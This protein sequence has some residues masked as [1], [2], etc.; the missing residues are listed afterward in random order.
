VDWP[1]KTYYKFNET[2]KGAE[3]TVS[4]AISWVFE[5]DEYAIILEDDIVAPLSFLK[6]AQ[7]MLINYKD[8]DRIGTVTGS[9]YTPISVPNNTDYFFAKYGHSGGGWATWKRVWDSFDLYVIVDDKHLELSFLKTIT[10]SNA[11]AKFLQRSFL[12]L[13]RRG[14]GNST[15]DHVGNYIFR[16]KNT[17][18]VIPR[19]NLT[20]NIGEYGLH[21]RGKSEHHHRPYD[22][23]FVVTK[24]PDKVESF[25]EFDKHHFK[26]YINRKTPLVARVIRKIK[27][28]LNLN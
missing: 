1:C 10:N 5:T 9:N 20:S 23:N 3:A 25:T 18:S 26:N 16:T 6:F 21:A 27:R 11:E 12:E 24:L 13:K 15:W 7:E 8:D 28:T 2:N 22:D 17:L 14:P 19:V 4:S